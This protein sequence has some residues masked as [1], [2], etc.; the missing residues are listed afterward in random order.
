MG[1][2]P[3]SIPAPPTKLV[4]PAVRP[5]L[6][7]VFQIMLWICLVLPLGWIAFK[8]FGN[9]PSANPAQEL[10]HLFGRVAIYALAFNLILGSYFWLTAKSRTVL[11]LFPNDLRLPLKKF[12]RHLGVAGFLYAFVHLGF[13]FLIEAGISDGFTA[14][15]EAKYLWVGSS[16]FLLLT[17][18]AVTSNN[19]AVRRLGKNWKTLHR[20][21]YAA[22]ALATAHTLMI[23]KADLIHFSVLAFVTALPLV[24]R[25][26]F[27][28]SA[29]R[30][31]RNA[32]R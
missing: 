6:R 23:E 11:R 10:T 28:A 8:F 12:R 2:A 1:P 4:N 15:V 22:F 18:L 9:G 13:H 14:I 29:Q 21:T 20:A 26:G 5:A 17:T 16:A 3:N 7:L 19:F 25:L 31:A 30:E 27:W 24:I 32:R